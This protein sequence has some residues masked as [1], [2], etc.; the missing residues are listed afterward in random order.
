MNGRSRPADALDLE[1]GFEQPFD[2]RLPAVV[3]GT[4][5]GVDA[6]RLP[7]AGER[8]GDGHRVGRVA[9]GEQV[10]Q[11]Q[12]GE[13]LGAERVEADE[14]GLGGGEQ[15]A[16]G[17]AAGEPLVGRLKVGGEVGVGG[18]DLVG[19]EASA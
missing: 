9:L 10:E 13:A 5:G 19:Q 17:H 6:A 7:A 15:G 12:I 18:G 3:R 4:L 2:E 14:A 16:G 11:G 8:H 1:P